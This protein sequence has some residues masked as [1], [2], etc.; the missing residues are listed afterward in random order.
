[1]S[2]SRLVADGVVLRIELDRAGLLILPVPVDALQKALLQLSRIGISN[3][4]RDL[5]LTEEGFD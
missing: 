3:V 4:D 5:P 1:L 2:I